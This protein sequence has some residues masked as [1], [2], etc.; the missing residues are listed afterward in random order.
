MMLRWGHGAN[1][2]RKVRACEPAGVLRLSARASE[3]EARR[4]QQLCPPSGHAKPT[5]TA[6][7]DPGYNTSSKKEKESGEGGGGGGGATAARS[8]ISSQV[9]P[10]VAPRGDHR[11]LGVPGRRECVGL[12]VWDVGDVRNPIPAVPRAVISRF[13][14]AVGQ[15]IVLDHI[16]AAKAIAAR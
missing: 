13:S 12:N 1:R 16:G 3:S 10:N 9:V 14:N 4:C 7:F 11:R 15:Q 2:E 5:T 8:A 6:T